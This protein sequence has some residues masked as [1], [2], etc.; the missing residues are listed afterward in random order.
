MPIGDSIPNDN[1]GNTLRIT[2]AKIAKIKL[3]HGPAK[4]IIALSR[5]GF[6]RLNG[7]NG[8]GFAHP[9]GAKRIISVPIGSKCASGL[10]VSLPSNRGVG[11]PRWSDARA[12]ANS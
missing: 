8:T 9:K 11:S 12:W 5:R 6:R 1:A 2:E 4:D 3:A 7:S 10:S